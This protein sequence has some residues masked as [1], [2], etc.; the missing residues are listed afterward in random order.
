[1]KVKKRKKKN[2]ISPV[3]FNGSC[4]SSNIK[5]ANDLACRICDA[6]IIK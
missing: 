1:M 4:T 2:I 5:E 6:L 3:F